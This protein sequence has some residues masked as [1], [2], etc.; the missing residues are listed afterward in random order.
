MTLF[1]ATRKALLAGV[2]VQTKGRELIDELI[3]KGEL[4]ETQGAK[5]IKEWSEKAD[6]T[7]KDFG[8]SITELIDKALDTMNLPARDDVEKLNRKVMALS[9]RIKKLEEAVGAKEAE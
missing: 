4:S 3:E 9:A 7:G 2:G 6:K 1:E 5:L 8:K